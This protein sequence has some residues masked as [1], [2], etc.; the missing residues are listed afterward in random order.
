MGKGSDNG[1][2]ILLGTFLV[3]VIVFTLRARFRSY[4]RVYA[5]V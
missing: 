3:G 1:L 2:V 5:P 4:D